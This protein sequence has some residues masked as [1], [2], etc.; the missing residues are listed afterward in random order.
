MKKKNTA[1]SI[2]QKHLW[3]C[4]AACV[5]F[6]LGLDYSTA[7]K[8]F[9]YGTHKANTRGFYCKEIVDVLNRSNRNYT[10]RYIKDRIKRRI[11]K[12]YTIVFIGRSPKYPVGHYLCRYQNTWMDPWINF[13][14][15]QNIQEAK[16]GFRK[17]LP[18][19]P[20]Y[21]ICPQFPHRS[22]CVITRIGARTF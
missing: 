15:N 11:Y 8:L 16:A 13:P 21:A 18:A 22:N 7:L 3:G 4:G 14:V 12:D 19:R 10:H 20:L 1:E 2:V 9:T 5:A 6:V 17:R